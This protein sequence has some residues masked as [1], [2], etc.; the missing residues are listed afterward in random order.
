M[1]KETD[2]STLLT[3]STIKTLY[4]HVSHESVIDYRYLFRHSVLPPLEQTCQWNFQTITNSTKNLKIFYHTNVAVSVSVSVLL[5][6]NM[7]S[8]HTGNI[9]LVFERNAMQTLS[10]N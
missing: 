5:F 4:N 6:H 2:R 3:Q 1:L 10:S 9:H 8:L 7:K